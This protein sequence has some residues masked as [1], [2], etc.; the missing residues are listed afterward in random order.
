MD[1]EK[2]LMLRIDAL[3]RELVARC[4]PGSDLTPVT[5]VFEL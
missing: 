5:K 3:E 1:G 4:Q 2:L